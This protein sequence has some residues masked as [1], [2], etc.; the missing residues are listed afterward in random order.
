M[1][2]VYV[3]F[4]RDCQQPFVLRKKPTRSS[5]WTSLCGGCLAFE[6]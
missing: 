1:T 4:C 5:K 2:I 3:R 6:I